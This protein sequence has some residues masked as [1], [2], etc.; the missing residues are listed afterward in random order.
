MG[1]ETGERRCVSRATALRLAGYA[2]AAPA[3]A[4]LASSLA[5]C[6]GSTPPYSDQTLQP[7]ALTIISAVSWP[8]FVIDQDG[9]A[10]GLGVTM[11]ETIGEDLGLEI[12]P[13][14]C[15]TEEEVYEA[16][17]A[18]TADLGGIIANSESIPEGFILSEP[19]MPCN[20][21]L[22]SKAMLR[23]QDFGDFDV[24]ETSILA[25]D[26]PIVREWVEATFSKLHVAYEADPLAILNAV[27]AG[28]VPFCVLTRPEAL[29]YLNSV[30]STLVEGLMEPSGKSFAYVAEE[31]NAELLDAVSAS[32]V[33][34]ED[35]GE[36]ASF[37]ARWFGTQ[38]AH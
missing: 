35:S 13:L 27:R 32:I 33:S 20:I 15:A 22:V 4:W 7:G 1:C 12:T 17:R 8:P 30:Y 23:E 31:A 11:C 25:I 24:P 26:Q 14:S 28:T 6:G 10:M 5:G 29:Y 2:F 36:I 19:V 9:E 3:M 34:L 16:L 38:L 37:E 21:S 18:R